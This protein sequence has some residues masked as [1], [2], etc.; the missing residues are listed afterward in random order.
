MALK[1]W[2]I[3]NNLNTSNA[4]VIVPTVAAGKRVAVTSL[5][6][7][8]QHSADINITVEVYDGTNSYIFIDSVVTPGE[9]FY[10]DVKLILVDGDS[11]R[12]NTD[13]AATVVIASGDEA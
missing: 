3:G 1:N 12:I 11:L 9:S 6:V 13:N 2:K 10:Y 7:N 4:N 5:V 8:N